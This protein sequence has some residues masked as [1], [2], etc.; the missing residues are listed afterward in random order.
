LFGCCND[1]GAWLKPS[2]SDTGHVAN[3]LCRLCGHGASPGPYLFRM[4]ERLVQSQVGLH[5]DGPRRFCEERRQRQA[6]VHHVP[7]GNRD[8]RPGAF[9]STARPGGAGQDRHVPDHLQAI[10]ELG[11]RSA[12]IYCLLDKR[13]FPRIAEPARIRF[14]EICEQQKS[15]RKLLQKTGRRDPYERNS[16]HCAVSWMSGSYG[17]ANSRVGITLS[18]VTAIDNSN[19]AGRIR[20]CIRRAPPSKSARYSPRMAAAKVYPYSWGLLEEIEARVGPA[21][22]TRTNNGP[23]MQSRNR[24][25]EMRFKPV[26]GWGERPTCIA[27][28]FPT[29]Q[30]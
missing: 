29:V 14:S 11:R 2:S 23:L 22:K 24:C 8:G 18:Y 26:I 20:R 9:H 30:G 17:R 1:F 16:K 25:E 12:R 7:S 19:R 13:L 5:H 15:R 27:A 6:M 3:N 4:D 21:K 28:T 10:F